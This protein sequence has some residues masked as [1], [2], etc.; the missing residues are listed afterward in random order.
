[1]GPDQ[2]TGQQ[3]LTDDQVIALMQERG[4]SLGTN[5]TV[6]GEDEK[7]NSVIEA[8][9][10]FNA[11]EG[12]SEDEIAVAKA[13]LEKDT[14]LGVYQAEKI[15]GTKYPGVSE[16]QKFEVARNFLAGDLTGVLEAVDAIK[17]TE[18]EKDAKQSENEK[19]LQVEGES[20]ARGAK[21]ESPISSLSD[22]F[23]A[24][25]MLSRVKQFGS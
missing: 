14:K 3:D 21:K 15:V 6:M 4:L 11:A 18:T 9:G 24:G 7:V 25:G 20:T 22:V 17:K 16:G 2:P 8:M 5:D 10:G 23:G 19:D 13:E 12:L 1:M